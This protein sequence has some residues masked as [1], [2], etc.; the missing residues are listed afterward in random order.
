MTDVVGYDILRDWLESEGYSADDLNTFDGWIG[1]GDHVLVYE[2]RDL[3]SPFL[4]DK[5]IVSYG[6]DQAQIERSQ[7]PEPPQRLPDI[8]EIIRWRYVLIKVGVL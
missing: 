7:Y 6:S 1:R 2:E 3:S 5:I 8:G 4:G